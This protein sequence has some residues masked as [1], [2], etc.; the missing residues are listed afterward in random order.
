M[1]YRGLYQDLEEIIAV[2]TE[3]ELSHHE[4]QRTDNEGT[5]KE[6]TENEPI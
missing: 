2:E 1:L 5:L 4:G 3:T 6:N